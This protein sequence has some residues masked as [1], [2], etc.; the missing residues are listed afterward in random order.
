[1]ILTHVDT[2]YIITNTDTAFLLLSLVLYYLLINDWSRGWVMSDG[3]KLGL[4]TRVLV[5]FVLI[6]FSAEEE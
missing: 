1:M 5:L 3:T 4:M 2:V 6:I